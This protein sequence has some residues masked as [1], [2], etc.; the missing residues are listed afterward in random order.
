MKY[1]RAISCSDI[2]QAGPRCSSS[3]PRRNRGVRMFMTAHSGS[4]D[5][6]LIYV[7]VLVSVTRDFFFLFFLPWTHLRHFS[8]PL[9]S[10]RPLGA[11][12]LV[13]KWRLSSVRA[14]QGCSVQSKALPA[15]R[16]NQRPRK[17]C[18]LCVF[19]SL[20]RSLSLSLCW[21]GYPG[22]LAPRLDSLAAVGRVSVNNTYI[23]HISA[24]CSPACIPRLNYWS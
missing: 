7:Y 12:R 19:V 1:W 3:P 24:E 9:S 4:V 23:L 17:H 2:R 11:E 22:S 13:E 18:A 15:W 21:K 8:T 16:Q 10:C 5:K 6:L 14:T 20:P